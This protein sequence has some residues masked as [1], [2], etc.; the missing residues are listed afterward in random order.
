MAR[1]DRRRR[2][3][4]CS[5]VRRSAGSCRS[6]RRTLITWTSASAANGLPG[7][8]RSR[9]VRRTARRAC[10]SPS[11]SS[12]SSAA[13]RRRTPARPAPGAMLGTRSLRSI[14]SAVSRSEFTL[15]STILW[16]EPGG[17]ATEGRAQRPAGDGAV[18]QAA[19]AEVV[20][21]ATVDQVDVRPFLRVAI[22]LRDE[23]QQARR[24]VP[25]GAARRARL[26]ACGQAAGDSCAPSSGS[27][28]AAPPMKRPRRTTAA[29]CPG[30]SRSART[31]RA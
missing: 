8:P 27:A 23:M 28:A 6:C 4:R 20:D 5:N 9:P 7:R 1:Q 2:W 22:A 31:A 11:R 13:S 16:T 19:H 18:Q 30:P 26:R 10:H 12:P 21:E 3:A 25:V 24:E 14:R 15:T 17:N 29:R